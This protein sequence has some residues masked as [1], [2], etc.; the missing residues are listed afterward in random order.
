MSTG[1]LTPLPGGRADAETVLAQ[2]RALGR[3][4]GGEEFEALL[5]DSVMALC[6]ATDGL[7]LRAAGP[8]D[9]AAPA[10]FEARV[11]VGMDDATVEARRAWAQEIAARC[12][13]RG[14]ALEPQGAVVRVAVRVAGLG[15]PA[16]LLLDIPA[17]ERAQLNELVLRARLVADLAAPGGSEGGR[18]GGDALVDV[19][20]IVVDV[21]RERRFGA[22][23]LALVN[24]IAAHLGCSVA[25][26]GWQDG[27]YVRARA[28]SHLDRFER[29]TENVQLL[30]AAFEEA[31]DQR[32]D[33]SWPEGDET[34]VRVAHERF[35]RGLGYPAAQSLALRASAE[36]PEAVLLLAGPPETLTQPVLDRVIFALQLLLPWLDNLRRTDRPMHE[37]ALASARDAI[38]QVVG[39]EHVGRKVFAIIGGLLLLWILLGTWP[40]RIEASAELRTDSTRVISAPYDSFLEEV[41]VTSGDEVEAG[42]PLGTLDVQDLYLQESEVR[43]DIRRYDAEADRARASG[44]LADVE[45]ALA[46]RAQ[47]AARLERV[48]YL[49]EQARITAPFGGVVVEGERSDLLG[50]PVQ[51][52]DRLFRLARV[53]GL[54]AVVRVPERDIRFID[55][56]GRGEL[57]L[58]SQPDRTVPFTV[59]TLIPVAQVEGQS[60]NF[61]MLKVRLDVA[62]QDWWRPGMAG[63]ARIDAGRRNIA[64][65][66]THR[67]L[68]TLRTRFWWW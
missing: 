25:C 5:V 56:D 34:L 4:A 17:R 3:A 1:S 60:G 24:G 31:L 65:L 49:L 19:L 20:E 7:L 26:L 33:L 47:S 42:A 61:F 51:Q 27:G 8:V 2:L 64:W 54:Y 29:K 41:H 9:A 43:A 68:D 40:H 22:A 23:S 55:D 13:E 11:C 30:E 58:L 21:M 36:D 57:R 46:R 53:E 35:S 16:L 32:T 38:G 62:P 63:M 44:L 10:A 59:E 12:L 39:L 18:A 28:I 6:R 37:R 50:R 67:L 52:G 15:A 48:L 66:L 14:F 45:I